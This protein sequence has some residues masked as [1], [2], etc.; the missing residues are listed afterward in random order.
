MGY[1]K[2]SRGIESFEPDETETEFY[3]SE[4]TGSINIAEILEKC[5]EKWNIDDPS[6]IRIHPEYI[7][8]DCIGYDLYDSRDYTKYLRIELIKE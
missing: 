4:W 2:N 5:K 1:Y 6:K 8:T 3:I 7:H